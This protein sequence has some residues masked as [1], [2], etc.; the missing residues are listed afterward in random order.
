MTQ[1]LFFKAIT[2]CLL[3]LLLLGTA[4]CNS[5]KAPSNLAIPS[6][7]PNA[8]IFVSQQAPVMVSL[9]TN[10][11]RLPN[12]ERDG[13]IAKLK[14]SLLAN[15]DID[16]Q[17]DIQPWLGQEITLAVTTLD[18]DREPENGSNPGYL[19]AL[20]TKEPEK[21][22][23]F[24]ELLFSKRSLAGANLTVEQYKG[25]KL[26]YEIPQETPAEEKLGGY[27]SVPNRQ[28]KT[29]NPKSQIQN[30]LAGAVVGD[31]FVLFANDPKVLRDAINN[32]QAPDLN[33]MSS[34]KYQQ[35]IKAL[36]KD[37]LAVA[38]LNLPT[39]A[40][41]QGLESETAPYN[42]Q[43]VSLV[44][45]RKGLIAET[46]L[47]AKEKNL[48]SPTTE[49][50]QPVGAL[51]YIPASAGLSVASS[52]L[53]NLD[54]SNLALLWQQAIAVISGSKEDVFSGLLQPLAEVQKHW[55]IN[56][57]DDVFDWVRGEYAIGLLPREDQINPDWIFVAEKSEETP[58]AIAHLNEIA[59]SGGLSLNSLKIGEQKISAWTELAAT[60]SQSALAKD[61]QV[62]TIQA[63]VLGAY[64]DVGNYEI[65]TSSIEAMDAAL[66]AKEDSL[67][68][69]SD[70]QNSIA[71]LPKP[72]QGYVYVD[73]TKSQ[74]IIESQLPFLK[75]VE[76]VGKSFFQNL[77]SLTVSSYGSDTDLL[78][79]GVFFQ[80]N[81]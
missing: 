32:V 59:S 1:R 31:N 48:L 7:Q 79:G 53:S 41:W 26:I 46:A 33:L 68:N 38:F 12:S 20:A 80:F 69:K 57:K 14:T 47:L 42:S 27:F 17:K 44:T 70:F 55:N 24:V 30:A 10:P 60:S 76:V 72:N 61:R 28:S 29:K 51:Q 52:N 75:L 81:S 71:A 3:M 15:T 78:K 74:P 22:R 54:N 66:T 11:E 63:K 13:E 39:V 65:I 40:K 49:I 8:A 36:P 56:W 34:S 18:L 73:W 16:Y 37:A 45:N 25:V 67:V 4:A 77:R 2:A 64:A 62:Y 6:G 21:S 19:M 43:I 58:A 50:A 23:E 5:A 35:A 9:L